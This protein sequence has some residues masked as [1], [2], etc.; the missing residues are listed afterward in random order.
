MR[1]PKSLK[2][3]GCLPTHFNGSIYIAAEGGDC[4]IS[5]ADALSIAEEIKGRLT[6]NELAG[7][8]EPGIQKNEKVQ[9]G[10]RIVK[11]LF[12][13][14]HTVSLDLGFSVQSRCFVNARAGDLYL[15]NIEANAAFGE[16]NEGINLLRRD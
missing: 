7:T 10:W 2:Y 15:V 16:I 5:Y 13:T 3:E 11:V 4:V 12:A 14:G 9:P 6:E 8:V 1:K